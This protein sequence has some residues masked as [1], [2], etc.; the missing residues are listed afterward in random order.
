MLAR[1][2]GRQPPDRARRRL[3][4]R[5]SPA[6]ARLRHGRVVVCGVDG[7]AVAAGGWRRSRRRGG[8]RAGLG[9]SDVGGAGCRRTSATARIVA[10]R[11]PRRDVE[12]WLSLC[13]SELQKPCTTLVVGDVDALGMGR[14]TGAR[15][16]RRARRDPTIETRVAVTAERFEDIPAPLAPLVDAI[17]GVPPLR[18]RPE[19]VLSIAERA[20]NSGRGRDVGSAGPPSR[21]ARLRLARQRRS[22]WCAWSRMRRQADFID[23]RITCHRRYSSTC[24]ID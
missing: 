5:E 7:P 1:S 12:A 13:D 9:T 10:A 11:P 18:D 22:S 8:R 14:R 3:P 2:L 24:H 6:R 21:A 17:V 19:D 15:P 4:R 20:A 23:V 16:H